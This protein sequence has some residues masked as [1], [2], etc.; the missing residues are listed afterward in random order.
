MGYGGGI[1]CVGCCVQVA[2]I[3]S[4]AQLGASVVSIETRTIA[5]CVQTGFV[6]KVII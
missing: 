5:A 4:R 1:G 3:E 6:L 2:G